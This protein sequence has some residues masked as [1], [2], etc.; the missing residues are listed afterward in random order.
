MI[1]SADEN[2]AI[3]SRNGLLFR[4]PP[5]LRRFRELTIG[6]AVI[7][8]RKTW[9][10]LP[11]GKPLPGRINIVM[12]RDPDRVKSARSWATDMTAEEGLTTGNSSLRPLSAEVIFRDSLSSLFGILDKLQ[13]HPDKIWVIGGAEIYRAL[14]PYC[15]EAYVTRF[16]AKYQEADSWVM[17]PLYAPGW[18]ISETGQ[19]QEWEGLRFRFDRYRNISP[20]PLRE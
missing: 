18:E 3:G 2:W 6:G 1:L 9:E 8:G 5:D 14:T 15:D 4:V 7:M 10:S 13:V 12:T 19:T 11:N 16:L 17:D 20:L